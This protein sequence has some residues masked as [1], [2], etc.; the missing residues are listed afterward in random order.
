MGTFQATAKDIRT[1]IGYVVRSLSEMADNENKMFVRSYEPIKDTAWEG[2]SDSTKKMID[3][4]YLQKKEAHEKLMAK[5]K[6]KIQGI[7]EAMAQNSLDAAKEMIIEQGLVETVYTG[8]TRLSATIEAIRTAKNKASLDDLDMQAVLDRFDSFRQGAD[9][10]VDVYKWL[11]IVAVNKWLM[12]ETVVGDD[13]Q[14]KKCSSHVPP[15]NSHEEQYQPNQVEIRTR[16]LLILDTYLENQLTL[17][18]N[19]KERL[20]TCVVEADRTKLQQYVRSIEK[21][22]SDAQKIERHDFLLLSEDELKRRLADEPEVLTCLLL[23]LQNLRRANGQFRND[24]EFIEEQRRRVAYNHNSFFLD[25]GTDHLLNYEVMRWL[26]KVRVKKITTIKE[27]SLEN[28]VWSFKN[29]IIDFVD[30]EEI[31][32]KEDQQKWATTKKTDDSLSY[33]YYNPFLQP[34]K[35]LLQILEWEYRKPFS[36]SLDIE[37]L[38]LIYHIKEKNLFDAVRFALQEWQYEFFR[39]RRE[40]EQPEYTV[41]YKQEMLTAIDM[42]IKYSLYNQNRETVAFRNYLANEQAITLILDW[43]FS[44]NN[45]PDERED[46]INPFQ[47]IETQESN[48]PA[49]QSYKEN[50]V[51]PAAY[52]LKSEVVEAVR[53]HKSGETWPDIIFY[54]IQEPLFRIAGSIPKATALFCKTYNIIGFENALNEAIKR[55]NRKQNK[56][57]KSSEKKKNDTG[58]I[59]G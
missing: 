29:A 17:V 23:G 18:E 2:C 52:E 6:A 57:K 31:A 28:I 10:Y 50:S 11:C 33:T 45:P 9:D 25:G 59:T 13:E 3:E 26:E 22:L 42:E 43:D 54:E 19:A 1:T 58:S 51:L 7:S 20:K 14:N 21:P 40:Q 37:L 53:L 15:G 35:D 8:L 34:L 44:R 36:N 12:G 5:L 49:I 39:D 55:R 4:E 27:I 47:Y 46:N 24:P 56:E 30:R 38:I 48:K 32:T 16:L 41:A